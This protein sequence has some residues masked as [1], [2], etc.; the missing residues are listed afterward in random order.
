[1]K[2]RKTS[3]DPI[4]SSETTRSVVREDIYI[5]EQIIRDTFHFIEDTG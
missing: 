2:K 3:I 1:M 4:S 5:T